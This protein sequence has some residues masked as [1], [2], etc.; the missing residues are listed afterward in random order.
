[1]DDHTLSLGSGCVKRGGLVPWVGE[2]EVEVEGWYIGTIPKMQAIYSA[3]YH[4]T[5]SRVEIGFGERPRNDWITNPA[6][7]RVSRTG[8]MCVG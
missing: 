2:L 8:D 5:P 4:H 7:T 1:M 3:P 6:N